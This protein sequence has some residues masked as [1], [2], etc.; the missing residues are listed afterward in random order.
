MTIVLLA[1]AIVL[2][3]LIGMPLGFAI[4]TA[5]LGV[6]WSTGTNP[7]IVAQRL[8]SGMDSFT[9]LAI[10][11]FLL[12]GS[13]MG[14]GGMTT[15]LVEFA[16]ALVGRFAGGLAMS[17]V[18]ASTF[19]SGISGSAVADTS[20]LGRIFI[21]AMEKE[22]YSRGFSVAVTAA[23]S[24]VAPIIPPSI[25]FIV[26]GVITGQSIVA[27][28]LAGIIPG[29]LFSA[30][31]LSYV[32]VTARRRNYPVH[33]P[34]SFAQIGVAFR[35]AI[36]AIAMP[37]LILVGIVSGIFTVTE[38]SAVAV[39]YALV[40]G[41]LV[42]RELTWN[43]LI[44]ALREAVQTTAV[45][46]IIV[47]AAQLF[48]WQLAYAQI[49][50]AAVALITSMSDNPI[51]FLLMINLLLLFIGT[52]MEANAAMVML[53][54]IL[55]P[56]GVALGVD[57]VQLGVVVIV[58]LCL[59]LITPPIGLCLAVACKIADLPL[60]KGVRDVMPFVAIGLV[61]LAA[62]SL[63]PALSLWLPD[64]VLK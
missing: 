59:G 9:L 57:P 41:G 36:A 11:F 43:G 26:Y 1:V 62:I 10:P 56:A 4:I 63:V 39:L 24:V 52:F 29:A 18:V 50:Q 19:F 28:F 30:V 3:I 53:V 44:E 17:N 12:A 48:A 14:R 35:R 16:N 40:V 42:Y 15:R 7:V 6:I 61:V 47:G 64:T 8:F 23:S 27:L 60:E 22:G 5:C 46:M 13:L 33:E 38:C 34:V 54:P 45:I 31:A 51:V 2:L 20:M 37:V 25:G 49:P 55:H 58:N 32:F 21:P